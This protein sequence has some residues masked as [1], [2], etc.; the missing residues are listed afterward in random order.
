M[1]KHLATRRHLVLVNDLHPYSYRLRYTHP[2][3]WSPQ[4][5]LSVFERNEW[6]LDLP[7][8][9]GDSLEKKETFPTLMNLLV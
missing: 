3:S 2:F 1:E 6:P 8:Q 9:V 7:R 5:C 4:T